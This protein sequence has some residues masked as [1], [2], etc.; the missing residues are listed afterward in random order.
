MFL[1]RGV[2]YAVGVI[3]S[4]VNSITEWKNIINIRDNRCAFAMFTIET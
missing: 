2:V 3:Y 1:S 4:N